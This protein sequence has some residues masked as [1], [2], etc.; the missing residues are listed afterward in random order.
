MRDLRIG[1]YKL[2]IRFWREGE[3]TVF[4]MIKGGPKLVERCDIGPRPPNSGPL[5]ILFRRLRRQ[6]A[7]LKAERDQS[8]RHELVP[9]T[10][11]SQRRRCRR[12]R[13]VN[14]TEWRLAH[15]IG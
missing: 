7:R 5:A 8:P 6:D 15:L 14:R 2:D 11:I 12:S 13:I 4:Q 10:V 9:F 1:K 3:E